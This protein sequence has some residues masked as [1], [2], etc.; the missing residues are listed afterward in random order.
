[1][2]IS[3]SHDKFWQ[4]GAMAIANKL[5]RCRQ[6]C[7]VTSLPLG[8]QASLLL[9]VVAHSPI[10]RG[11]QRVRQRKRGCVG[12]SKRKPNNLG[13]RGNYPYFPVQS[14]ST[15]S[16]I[17]L[18]PTWRN[19]TPPTLPSPCHGGA[20]REGAFNFSLNIKLDWYARNSA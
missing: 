6:E 16:T 15:S 18:P 9:P 10:K 4:D 8:R 12:E 7:H 20:R 14:T 2:E 13:G 5:E 11:N 1:M 19:Y 17:W 3:W